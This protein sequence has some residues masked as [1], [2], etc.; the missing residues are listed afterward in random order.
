MKV[1]NK[2]YSALVASGLIMLAAGC[3]VDNIDAPDCHITGKL[4]SGDARV[5][6][7]QSSGNQLGG[8][9]VKMELWQAG[10]GK[11]TAQEINVAQDGTFAVDVYAG[12][13]RI[14]AKAGVGPWAKADTLR[15]TVDRNVDVTYPVDAY[16]VVTE[17]VIEYD[18]ETGDFK[19]TYELIVQN[20]EAS[21]VQTGIVINDTRFVDTNNQKKQLNSQQKSGLVTITGNL[22]DLDGKRYL[23]ARAFVK[24]DKS[25]YE[26]YSLHPQQLR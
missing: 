2:I 11:E 6:V 18:R 13:V 24:T 15:L 26:A 17:P 22:S 25:S 10:F 21:V 1:M 3:A 9:F 19:A 4:L 14:I 16:A 5:G 20:D 7:R 12:K 8:S 23:F